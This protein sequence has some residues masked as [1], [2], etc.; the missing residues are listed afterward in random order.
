MAFTFYLDLILSFYMLREEFSQNF[1]GHS[2]IEVSQR[3][4]ESWKNMSLEVISFKFS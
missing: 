2:L 4:F 1:E 3:G